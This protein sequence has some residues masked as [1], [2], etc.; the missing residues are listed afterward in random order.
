MAG[1]LI[2]KTFDFFDKDYTVERIVN[3]GKDAETTCVEDGTVRTFPLLTVLVGLGQLT[4][5][6]NGEWV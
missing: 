3:E 5:I 2:G 6:G 4:Y 1:D